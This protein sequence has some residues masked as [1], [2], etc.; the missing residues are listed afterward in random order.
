M[1]LQSLLVL[2]SCPVGHMSWFSS[3][4]RYGFEAMSEILE[5]YMFYDHMLFLLSFENFVVFWGSLVIFCQKCNEKSDFP[6]R[7]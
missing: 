3:E 6:I 4:F 5:C 2:L 7:V 1:G